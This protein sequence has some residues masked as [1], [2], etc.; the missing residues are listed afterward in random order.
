[1]S[2]YVAPACK[3]RQLYV[4][5]YLVVICIYSDYKITTRLNGY[6]GT[7]V[8]LLHKATLHHQKL[9]E[10]CSLWVIFKYTDF[11]STILMLIPV[12]YLFRFPKSIGVGYAVSVR[13]FRK[14]HVY[15]QLIV[16]TF[17]CFKN[18][19][20]HSK[21][22]NV[23]VKNICF[24]IYIYISFGVHCMYLLNNNIF[25]PLLL[26]YIQKRHK[27]QKKKIVHEHKRK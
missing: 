18:M 13:I 6:S 11:S 23:T 25:L 19:I 21:N 22:N 9:T 3:T 10:I 14:Q 16:K 2:P 4:E 12:N 26:E 7:H 15:R 8:M 1:M 20:Y 24:K 27:R 5:H 17:S